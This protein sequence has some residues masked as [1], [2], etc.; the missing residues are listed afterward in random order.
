VFIVAVITQ[1]S[2]MFWWGTWVLLWAKNFRCRVLR[3]CIQKFLDWVD[4]EIYAYILYY[5]LEAT[6]RVMAAKLTRLSHEILI[7]LHLVAE[8]CTI[9]SSRSRRPVRKLLDTPS[10]LT[11]LALYFG[12]IVAVPSKPLRKM[13]QGTNMSLG[14]AQ[15]AT[16]RA[17]LNLR[18]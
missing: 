6:Q 13:S 4:N 2:A 1:L 10:Y 3:G 15:K 11:R 17:V 12:W 18:A 14:S 7:Q 9:C 16:L 8:G 5:S